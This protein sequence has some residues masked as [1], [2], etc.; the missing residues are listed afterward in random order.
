MAK[1]R[2]LSEY[3]VL[4]R[5]VDI[6]KV[7]KLHKTVGEFRESFLEDHLLQNV[8]LNQGYEIEGERPESYFTQFDA[9]RNRTKVLIHLMLLEDSID[10]ATRPQLAIIETPTIIIP[11]QKQEPT[12][13]TPMGISLEDI[14]ELQHDWRDKGDVVET[15]REYQKTLKLA[16]DEYNMQ[17]ILGKII[18]SREFPVLYGEK[19]EKERKLQ[20][21]IEDVTDFRAVSVLDS[22]YYGMGNR[23]LRAGDR[24]YKQLSK[25]NFG[26]RFLTTKEEE[27]EYITKLMTNF[28]ESDE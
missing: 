17:F 25:D 1:I 4:L 7:K 13:K 6:E 18:R 9:I 15:I 3:C 10:L 5:D 14:E 21:R 12:I 23:F 26:R 19:W 27:I 16:F 28:T 24:L 22:A 20:K 11:G 8:L 2:D